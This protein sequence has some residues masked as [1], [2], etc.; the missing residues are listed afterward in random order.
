MDTTGKPG[1]ETS[2]VFNPKDDKDI[3]SLYVY[4][5]GVQ[6]TMNHDYVIDNVSTTRIVFIGNNKPQVGD[7]VKIEYYESKQPI[8][9]PATPS[10]FADAPSFAACLIVTPGI[11]PVAKSLWEVTGKVVPIPIVAFLDKN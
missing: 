2:F 11:N 10:K 1:L 5:N 8:W 9:I 7:V 3:K 6:L 4:N